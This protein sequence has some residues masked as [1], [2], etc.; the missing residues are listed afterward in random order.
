MLAG[1]LFAWGFAISEKDM[2][3]PIDDFLAYWGKM[4]LPIVWL[5]DMPQFPGIGDLKIRNRL[6]YGADMAGDDPIR[7]EEAQANYKAMTSIAA[8]RFDV[9]DSSE[10]YCSISNVEGRCLPYMSGVGWLAGVGGHLSAVGE[11]LFV[12]SLIA[13][14]RTFA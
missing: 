5:S 6:A 4:R 2:S 11:R 1:P 7:L 3:P 10:A 14:Y 13:R 12:K 8:G 9:L